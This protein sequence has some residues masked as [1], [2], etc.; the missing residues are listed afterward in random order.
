M[1]KFS[2][3][4][5]S[6][7][8]NALETG[9]SRGIPVFFLHPAPGSRVMYKPQVDNANNTGVRLISYSRPGYG[10]SEREEGRNI[11]G[12][13]ED[14]LAIA[15]D[16]GIE[17][18]G[19][20]GYAEGAP[21]A[22]SCAAREPERVVAISAI[23]GYA[24]FNAEGFDFFAGMGDYATK[25]F[26]ML[27]NKDQK[28]EESNLQAVET[29]RQSTRDRLVQLIGS[30]YSEAD[31]KA[32]SDDLVDFMIDSVL[33]G[34]SEGI[35]GVR[36]DRLALTRLWGFDVGSIRVPTQIWHGEQDTVVPIQHSQ[37]LASEIPGA[38]VHL[39]GDEGHLSTFVNNINDV[40]Q[41]IR[42]EFEK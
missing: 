32:V 30:M 14:V 24:P 8:L 16:L 13:A 26:N 4:S 2:V 35:D 39:E 10:G 12:A 36:E 9:A 33:D 41:W 22:L 38:E 6:R 23:S 31:A 17:R 20:I 18:F 40:Q 29:L 42:S 21:H 27:L 5:G 1:R 15:D 3:S 11:S 37:W 7:K 19:V 34:C 28:W 25:D